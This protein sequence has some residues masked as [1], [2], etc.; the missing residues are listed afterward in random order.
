[1]LVKF[2]PADESLAAQRWRDLL[3]SES[4]AL[5]LLRAE[6][7]PAAVAQSLSIE[8]RRFLEV[9]RFDCAVAY[10]GR[11]GASDELSSKFRQLAV[12]C[13]D[14]VESLASQILGA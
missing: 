14:T 8:G 6:G 7:L 5:K 10:W 9:E 4:L 3:A 2:S 11:L 1:M 12:R 13:R